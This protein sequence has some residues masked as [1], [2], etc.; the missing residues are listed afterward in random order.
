M[1]VGVL[2]AIIF[3]NNPEPSDPD[4]PIFWLEQ[5]K[6][7]EHE[8]RH[9]A[10]SVLSVVRPRT[11]AIRFVLIEALSDPDPQ[12]RF[13]AIIALRDDVEA[14]PQIELLVQDKSSLV[15]EIARAAL[16]GDI[17]DESVKFEE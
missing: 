5:F 9:E 6:S 10:V 16:T 13:S 17:K 15:R 3:A 7:G 4:D 8:L 11:D 2:L 14:R 12:I 1:I